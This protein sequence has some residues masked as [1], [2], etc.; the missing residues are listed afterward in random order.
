MFWTKD[1]DLSMAFVIISGGIPADK[2]EIVTWL[3]SNEEHCKRAEA[4]G[5]ECLMD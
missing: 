1:E 5:N 2:L 4:R 3:A